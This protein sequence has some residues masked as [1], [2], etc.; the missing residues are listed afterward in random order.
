MIVLIYIP[1][2]YLLY[3]VPGAIPVGRA[4]YGQGIGEI[5]YDEMDC[6]GLERNLSDCQSATF[7]VHNCQH[8][9]DAGVL[10]RR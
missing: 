4:V 3:T 6:S 7:R 1:L 5:L 9:E 2:Q 8:S 10:C